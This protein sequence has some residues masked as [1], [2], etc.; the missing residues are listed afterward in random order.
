MEINQEEA[1]TI[2]GSLGDEDG[3]ITEEETK[4][5]ERIR[6]EFPAIDEGIK[7][8]EHRDHLWQYE[9]EDDKRVKEAREKLEKH[10]SEKDFDAILHEFMGLKRKVQHELLKKE[11]TNHDTETMV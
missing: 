7:K 3:E 2:L 11:E 8:A 10:F 6:Q 4:L 5:E 9:V 1:E